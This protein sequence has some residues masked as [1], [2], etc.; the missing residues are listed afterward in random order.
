MAHSHLAEMLDLDA[1]VLHEFHRDVITWVG[2]VTPA[3]SRIIDLGAGTGTGA[4]ALARQLPDAEVVAVDVSESMLEHLRHKA[5]ALGVADRIHTVQADLDQLW[6]PLSPADLVWASASLHHMADPGRALT[7]A[8]ATLRPGGALVVTELDSFPRFLPDEAG[9]ALEDRCH[10]ALA[11]IRAEAGMH[12][13]EDWGARLAEAGFIV[14]AERHFDIALQPPLP[15][16]T[17]RYAQVSLQRMRHGLDGRLDA[18]DLAALDAL[19][20]GVPGRDDLTVR[21][22]RTVWLAR[23]PEESQVPQ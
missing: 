4:L 7:Q 14:E 2:S 19:A 6:P 16:A 9:A 5:S 12:M 13:G 15:A 3:R 1:D 11:E 17:G 20:A 10:D 22:T 21:A 18:G 23:R 8:L